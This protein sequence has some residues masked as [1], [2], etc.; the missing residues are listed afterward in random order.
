MSSAAAFLPDLPASMCAR[1]YDPKLSPAVLERLR[2]EVASLS[3]A[4]IVVKDLENGPPIEAPI[5]VRIFSDN[6]DTLAGLAA[7]VEGCSAAS[8]EPRRSTTRCGVGP[9]ARGLQRRKLTRATEARLRGVDRH[10]DQKLDS[11]RRLHQPTPR[12]GNRTQGGDRT[13][14]RNRLPAGCADHCYRPR[15][16][17]AAANPGF[18]ALLPLAIVI[19]GGLLSSLLLSRLVT[20]VLYSLMPPPMPPGPAVPERT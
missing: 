7:Q 1:S 12:S 2:T 20:P 10:R 5:A 18:R 16:A 15:S 8:R 9:Q 6:L 11:P 17:S 13:R 14:G 19:I 4:R 3:G